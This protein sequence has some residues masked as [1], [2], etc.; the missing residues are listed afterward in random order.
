MVREISRGVRAVGRVQSFRKSGKWQ[1]VA[2]GA[3]GKKVEKKTVVK[4]VQ[5]ASKWYAADDVAVPLKSN[6]GNN[7][8]TKLRASI[9][10][11]TV[12]I[13]LAGRFRGKRVVF[14]K[15]LKNGLLLV[16]GPFK[17]NGVPLRRVNQAYVIATSTKL[18]I[19]KVD[20]SAVTDTFFAKKVVRTG[21]NTA[22]GDEFFTEGT[23][24]RPVTDEKKAAQK[25]IDAQLLPL[26]NKVQFLKQYL[27]AKFSLTDKALPHLMKF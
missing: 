23:K 19:S 15:Q 27:N 1:H 4:Q 21:Q 26:V 20:I 5:N 18:D 3:K 6:K 14:L 11:G 24:S 8:G 2:K 17:I 16:S 10:P 13:I 25:A 7:K 9:T 12:L 22:N